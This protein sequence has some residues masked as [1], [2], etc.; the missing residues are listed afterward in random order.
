MRESRAVLEHR[1]TWTISGNYSRLDLAKKFPSY[2]DPNATFNFKGY[3]NDTCKLY[4]D[5]AK[6]VLSSKGFVEGSDFNLTYSY[7][8]KER[9]VSRVYNNFFYTP[10]E[11]SCNLR[12]VS[13]NSSSLRFNDYKQTIKG[14]RR[15]KKRCEDEYEEYLYG[16]VGINNVLSST[17]NITKNLRRYVC[18]YKVITID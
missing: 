12:Y 11:L 15:D 5:K 16:E 1:I 2:F 9:E 14:G 13:L 4:V 18:T 8:Y 10:Y 3:M 6:T 7:A 17:I